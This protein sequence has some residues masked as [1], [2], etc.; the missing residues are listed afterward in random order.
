MTDII[1]I[2]ITLI[3]GLL[4]YYACNKSKWVLIICLLWLLIQGLIA[5]SG[6]YHQTKT[7]PPR[8]LLMVLPPILTILTLFYSNKAKQ[9]L[10]EIDLKYLYAIHIIRIP[11]ELVLYLLFIQ[12]Q[13]PEI[14]TFSGW[15]YDI[16]SGI[17]A[18]F[19]C[20]FG[21]IKKK[22][23]VSYL[24]IWNF[25]CLGFL[26][27][28]VTIAVLSAPFPFQRL[29]FDQPNIAVLDFPINFLPAFVVPIVLFA[30][31]VAIKRYFQNKQ[32]IVD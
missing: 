22:I 13:V 29:A 7:I 32:V 25:I 9:F 28:I 1:F 12:K 3:T 19:V 5:S 23:K 16:L 26:I 10:L 15:N 2:F 18:I 20:Y 31:V 27:N 30:H 24:L 11:V 21:I 17:S 4:L 14:M 8:F 6:F